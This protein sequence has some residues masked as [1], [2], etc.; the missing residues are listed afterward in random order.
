MFQAA[1]AIRILAQYIDFPFG[2]RSFLA[3]RSDQRP[4]TAVSSPSL[5][6]QKCAGALVGSSPAEL[7]WDDSH[8]FRP[9][10]PDFA[11]M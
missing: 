6:N 1:D 4:F 11:Y 2:M 7:S 10:A 8:K 9:Y 3:S 5:L